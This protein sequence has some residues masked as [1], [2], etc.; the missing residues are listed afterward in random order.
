MGLFK[1]RADPEEIQ[2]LRAEIDSMSERLAR[3]DAAKQQTETHVAQ[4]ASRLDTMPTIAPLT[5]PPA[6]PPPTPAPPEVSRA[7]LAAVRADVERL[8]ERLGEVDQ[9][10][11]SISRELAN[12]LSE[13]AN[14]VEH[15]STDQPP[16]ERV[17][18]ELRDA[19]ARLAN[20]QARYQIAFRQDLAD[21]V[22]RLRRT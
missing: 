2:R 16:T 7:D 12:Q 21:L 3:A 13:L 9:R 20:E 1:R 19:Q 8:S 22:D 18:D 6:E 5:E 11:E 17:V 15:L 10:I 4:L 14:E